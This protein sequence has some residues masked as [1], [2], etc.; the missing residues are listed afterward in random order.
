MSP[1]FLSQPGSVSSEHAL[2]ERA[3]P[4]VTVE[5]IGYCST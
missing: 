4:F 5:H 1:D 2:G 3:I